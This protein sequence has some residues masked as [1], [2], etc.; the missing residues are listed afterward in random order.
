MEE[1]KGR[2]VEYAIRD[3]GSEVE[4]QVK[5]RLTFS[6]H[7][8]FRDIV[9]SLD[10]HRNKGWVIELSGLEFIDSAGL[11]MLLIV[12]D[13]ASQ[14]GAKVTL[15]GAREQA[16]RLIQVARFDSLFAVE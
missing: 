14:H 4:V 12:R 3:A 10:S 11:G 15:R 13:A 7:K 1:M 16:K 2:A 5:G 9:K 6:D 8:T